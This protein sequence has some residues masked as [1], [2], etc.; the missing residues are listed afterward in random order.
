MGILEI[1][2][3]DFKKALREKRVESLSVL[4]ILKTSLHNKEI[5]LRP[6]KQELN[7]EIA[8]EVIQREVKKRREAV[9][10]FEKGGRSDLVEKE[11]KELELLIK[12]LPEQLS[13]D[14]IRT[15]VSEVIKDLKTSGS[16][17]RGRIMGQVMG[18]L[19]GRA[20]GNRVNQIVQEELNN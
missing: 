3:R 4:R 10:M 15:I 18:R 16:P 19:K 17:D 2:E 9:E 1:I 12:Y 20:D 11:R 14:K 7:D 8:V 6:S 13:D 5:E